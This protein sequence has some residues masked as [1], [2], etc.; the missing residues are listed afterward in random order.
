METVVLTAEQ[1]RAVKESQRPIQ[2]CDP[3]GNLLGYI[4]P[5]VSSE[6]DIADAQQRLASSQPRYTSEQVK[7][8]LH[9]LDEEWSRTGGFDEAHQRAF[10]DRRRSEGQR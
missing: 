5:L 9:A 8:H 10:L 7:E 4:A 3:Q 6:Q 2:V 1:A